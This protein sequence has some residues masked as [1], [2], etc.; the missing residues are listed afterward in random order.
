MEHSEILELYL[1]KDPRAIEESRTH[2][3]YTCR[4][5]AMN[6]LAGEQEAESCLS[7]ALE[8][9][10]ESIPPA[11]PVHLDIYI[12]KLTRS[13]AL[14]G[15]FASHSVKRG[16]NLF[17]SVAD[18][19]GECRP[20][21]SGRFSGGFD[22]EA[23]AVRA[24]E[25]LARF[26]RKQGGE[27]GDLFLCRYFY[28]ESLSEIARRFGLNENRVKSRL[29]KLRGKLKKFLEQ[30]EGGTW[31]PDAGTLAMGLNYVDDALVMTAHGTAKKARR[32][33]PWAAA[34]CV[35]AV[36][37]VSFPYLR[38]F[39]NT[40][41]VLRGPD[42]NKDKDE[43]GD[44]EIAHKPSADQILPMGTPAEVAGSTL[45]LTAV[46]ETSVTLT[47]EKSTD[48]PLYTAVYDRM[49]DALACTDP[50]YK[51]DGVTIR[52]GRIKVYPADAAEGAAEPETVL[53]SAA[54]TY[55]VVVDFTSV[56]NGT[57]PMENYLGVFAYSGKDG[58]PETVYFSLIV[59]ET[60][61]DTESE[62][63]TSAETQPQA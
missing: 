12:L 35:I 56:R 60:E 23:E 11:R 17:A 22:P 55:T 29:E 5:V 57:Y 20:A 15:Y 44:A 32:L 8:R 38:T 43:I 49:G 63:G 2:Y 45:T 21:N 58:A 28:A 59:P 6:I 48:E 18:E 54:G 13:A 25:C 39:I 36:L 33:I 31:E 47:I 51:V 10:W 30:E 34:A 16:Y 4:R 61:T 41:L 26:L 24:G 53:P 40:D 19:L 27:A 7:A 46:T 42:W 62:G 14:E 3:G 9:A 52:A 37:A 1:K 50:D